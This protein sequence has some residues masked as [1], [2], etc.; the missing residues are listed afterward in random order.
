[1][2][3]DAYEREMSFIRRAPI[4]AACRDGPKTRR[5]LEEGTDTSRATVYR[6]TTELE[7]QGLL[8]KRDGGYVTTPAGKAV[9]IGVENFADGME[10][11]ERLDPLFDR[12][13]HPRLLGNAHLLTG[14][15]LTVADDDNVYRANDRVLELWGRSEKIR[16]CADVPG[17]RAC[18]QECIETTLE[19]NVDV[20]VYYQ[21]DSVPSKEKMQSDAFDPAEM[22]EYFDTFVSDTVPFTFILYD[23]TA[24]IAGHNEMNIP[25]VLAETEEPR[26]YQWLEGIYA[27]CQS[28]ASQL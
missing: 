13:T 22:F 11:I 24:A 20:D 23:D 15:E 19:N 25:T 1:M 5:E 17:S 7:E 26:V 21:P 16:M 3:A 27:E 2:S 4:L 8:E 12:V 6:A 10:A 28:S 9:S 14:A 18:L